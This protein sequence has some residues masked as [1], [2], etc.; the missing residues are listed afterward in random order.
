MAE[1]KIKTRLSLKY[2]TLEHWNSSTI[3]L[4]KGEAAVATVETATKDAKGNIIY[5]PTT[6][7]KYGD[8]A[9][10]FA[11]LP[12]SSAIA[13]DVYSWAKEDKLNIASAGNGNV[14]SGIEW[15]ATANGGKGG[16][17]Y[18]TASVATAEGLKDIQD[19]TADLE[20]EVYG[21]NGSKDNSRIDKLEKTISDNDAAWKA[22]TT[23]SFSIPTSG[24]DK[25]KLLIQKTEVGGTATKVVALDF[26]TPDE[27][28]TT[29]GSY[30]TKTEADGKFVAQET[31]KSLMTADEHTK[32]AGIATGATKVES[33]TNGK[34]KINGA[35]TAVYTLETDKVAKVKV[36]DADHADAATKVDNTLT[37]TVG[38]ANVV[39][40]GSTVKTAN[41]DAAIDAAI[42]DRTTYTDTEIDNKVKVAKDAADAAQND[43][44]IAKT[45]IETFLGTVTPDGSQDIID[46]L[47]E[48][49]SYVGE[50]GE[51]FAALSEKVTKIENGTTP[52]T[53]GDLTA[54]LE[55]EIKGY[56]VA[57][58]T[59][60]ANA[61]QLGGQA[62]AYYATAASVTDITKTNGTIDTKVKT[63]ID[64]EVLRADGKYELDGAEERAIAA[65]K[66]E[67]ETQ[68]TTLTTGTI[69]PLA[70]RV[71]AI[72]DAPYATKAQV[73]AKLNAN[74]W[75]DHI[76]ADSEEDGWNYYSDDSHNVS[77]HSRGIE[78]AYEY[79]SAD[80]DVYGLS[81]DD[82][83]G[84]DYRNASYTYQGVSINDE[85]SIN[86]TNYHLN[87]ITHN[88]VALSFSDHSGTIAV[89]EDFKAIA[90]SGSIYD[91]VEK[92]T[93]NFKVNKETTEKEVTYLVFDCG[94]AFGWNN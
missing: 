61:A 69:N 21:A 94:D 11:N 56:T 48:I 25:G 90:K 17:K 29:L 15:D 71:K 57:N 83:A 86:T 42:G 49:N 24:N 32:L 39:F 58:A 1:N 87:G 22:N 89:D 4:N 60:A 7:V 75:T 73:D 26:I 85:H 77:I 55:A 8:G 47:A 68:I 45:K 2:D 28:T 88:S 31:N 5:V 34:I 33:S 23:Y 51:E 40:D 3:V 52:T 37:I 20:T 54:A 63:A 74:G 50:H 79:A 78:Y 92:S 27:L 72:E 35:D 14:V 66:Q 36:E 91:V 19:R 44:T 84:E 30:Y 59:N 18:T 9:K 38:K 62:P 10:T 80:L 93:G 76:N 41:V 82:G 81:V 12:F 13:A 43:A 53:A 67:T 16:V 70:N 6:L 64:A 65:A 46:T